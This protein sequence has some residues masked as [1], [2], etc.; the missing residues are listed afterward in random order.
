[1]HVLHMHPRCICVLWHFVLACC[2]SVRLRTLHARI[3]VSAPPA[4]N[5]HR[6]VD[7]QND[8]HRHE[9]YRAKMLAIPVVSQYAACCRTL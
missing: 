7:A 9:F 1:M 2:V 3:H 5:L 4:A 8:C 6:G